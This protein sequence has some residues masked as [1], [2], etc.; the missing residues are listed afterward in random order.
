[1]NSVESG[2]VVNFSSGWCKIADS[3]ARLQAF[4]VETPLVGK[5]QEPGMAG[6]SS[7]TIRRD[8]QTLFD[9]GPRMGCPTGSCWS[10]SL[11]GAIRRPNRPSRCW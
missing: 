1:M 6:S 9:A 3:L 4:L 5:R 2:T 7:L 10:G 11:I 8:I